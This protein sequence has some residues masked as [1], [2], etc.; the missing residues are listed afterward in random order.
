MAMKINIPL[1]HSNGIVPVQYLSY[2]EWNPEL[3]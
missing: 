1:F 3:T 2:V